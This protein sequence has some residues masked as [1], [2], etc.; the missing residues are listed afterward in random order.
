V[1]KAELVVCFA[2]GLV[3]AWGLG[4]SG[5]TQPAR[6]IGFLDVFGAWDPTLLMVMGG[7]VGVHFLFYRWMSR[8]S[9][10]LLAPRFHLPQRR[11][12]TPSLFVGAF[13]F[14]TGWGLAGYCPG[15]SIVSA[16]SLDHRPV[17]FVLSMLAGMLVYRFFDALTKLKR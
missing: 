7:A 1:R 9:S 15:P 11:E 6:V 5:M 10:P 4:I 16:V 3:F 14:G 13:V 8:R 12:L 2:V 17:I